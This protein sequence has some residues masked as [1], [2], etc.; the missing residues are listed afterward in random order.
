VPWLDLA[1]DAAL[2]ARLLDLAASFEHDG[3]VPHAL[4][5]LVTPAE[6]EARWRALRS[7]GEKNGHL[8]VTNGP[9]RLKAWTPE[10]VVLEA[11]REMTYPLGFG[12][13]DRFVKPP[14]AVIAAVTREGDQVLV[15]ADAE[16]VIKAG[17]S[18]QFVKEP[19]LHSTTRGVHGLFVVS[20]YLLIGPDGQVIKVDKMQWKD[21]GQFAIK[22]PEGLPV[23]QH[24]LI[25]G[26]FLDGNTLHPSAKVLR[27][28]IGAA[29]APD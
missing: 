9:Y 6:A 12:T 8:L 29:G 13:F 14:T 1:R 21:D 24:T 22:L 15:R 3:Y 19:L 18:Y 4:K 26:V 20:R 25:L 17:R 2:R 7:F 27:L 16:M 5:D 28:R 10:M 11:V 23:G